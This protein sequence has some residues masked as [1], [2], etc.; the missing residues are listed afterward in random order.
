MRFVSKFS[1]ICLLAFAAAAP[2][3][4]STVNVD[5]SGA[6][7]GATVTGVGAS[8]AQGFT[9]A[10]LALS[11]SGSISVAFFNPGVSPA[12]N[13]LLSQP[14]NQAALAMYLDGATA[15]SL[16]FTAG[17]AEGGAVTL[18]GYNAAGAATGSFLLN[19]LNG[20]NVYTVN[21]LG[22]FAGVQFSS[23]DDPA[24]VRYMNFSYEALMNGGVPEPSTWALLILGFGL[25]GAALRRS[26]QQR[27]AVSYA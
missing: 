16:T 1:S 17:S 18:T 6:T 7:T 21:S 13:S 22:N 12:S 27:V 8:F 14:N 19:F 2:A 11:P 4:A 26:R 9:F 24:G 15:N 20:Y 10:P 25:T 5:L 23:T 3:N